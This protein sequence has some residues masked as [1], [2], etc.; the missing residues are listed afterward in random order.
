MIEVKK[1]SEYKGA[2]KFGNCISCDIRISRWPR[3][4]RPNER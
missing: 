1:L 3:T 4:Q 2:S